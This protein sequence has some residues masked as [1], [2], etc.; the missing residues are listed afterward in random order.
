MTLNVN[1]KG[2]LCAIALVLRGQYKRFRAAR[3]LRI[4]PYLPHNGSHKA[5]PF[6]EHQVLIVRKTPFK[7]GRAHI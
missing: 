6:L 4:A 7:I 3:V 1:F 5:R 2:V